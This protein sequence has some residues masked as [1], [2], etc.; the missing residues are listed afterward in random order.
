MTIVPNIRNIC[1]SSFE[2]IKILRRNWKRKYGGKALEKGRT[3]LMPFGENMVCMR[4]IYWNNIRES[5]AKGDKNCWEDTPQ[6]G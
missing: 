1:I 6:K 5:I 4:W 2:S 3:G